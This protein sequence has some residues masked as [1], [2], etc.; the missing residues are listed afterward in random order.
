MSAIAD[1][2]APLCMGIKRDVPAVP[3]D[4]GGPLVTLTKAEAG[5]QNDFAPQDRTLCPSGG[6]GRRARFRV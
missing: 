5:R 3:D 1:L 4:W 6:T 2:H